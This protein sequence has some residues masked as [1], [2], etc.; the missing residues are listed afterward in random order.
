ERATWH[1]SDGVPLGIPVPPDTALA[2]LVSLPS[3]PHHQYLLVL[4]GQNTL[5]EF[6]RRDMHILTRFTATAGVAIATARSFQIARLNIE[7]SGELNIQTGQVQG[8]IDMER[9]LHILLT[10]V[11]AEYGLQFNRAAVLLYDGQSR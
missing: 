9:I 4:A 8:G 11:T 1:Q 6:T 3:E 7:L 10:A 2:V 5:E